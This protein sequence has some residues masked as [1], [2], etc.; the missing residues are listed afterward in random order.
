RDQRVRAARRRRAD[1]ALARADRAALAACRWFASGAGPFAYTG[2]VANVFARTSEGLDR[3]DL[4]MM[5]L[6][7]SGDARMWWPGLQRKPAAMLSARTGYL[8][9]RSRGWVRLRSADPRDAPR[10]FLN[11]F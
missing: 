2:T 1:P 11:M 5:C 8:P 9:L 6:P 3:P 10:I 4:Q 7:L